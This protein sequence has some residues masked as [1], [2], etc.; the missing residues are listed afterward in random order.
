MS[1]FLLLELCALCGIMSKCKQMQ[2][3]TLVWAVSW[4]LFARISAL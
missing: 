3:Y 1:V 4:C 2:E